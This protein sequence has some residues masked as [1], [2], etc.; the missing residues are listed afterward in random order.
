MAPPAGRA[1]LA[2]I[3]DEEGQLIFEHIAQL[4]VPEGLP[5][6]E[7]VYL[8]GLLLEVRANGYAT[9]EA[10]EFRAN[11]SSMAV[12]VQLNGAT[13]ACV[14]IIWVRSAMTISEA[15]TRYVDVLLEV[16]PRL[17]ASISA[18][19]VDSEAK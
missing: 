13:L 6:L 4:N 10:G 19:R 16:A 7:P 1:Y 5:Y 14:S 12:P 3:S 18:E 8:D 2:F 9:R 15:A 11:T 17:A